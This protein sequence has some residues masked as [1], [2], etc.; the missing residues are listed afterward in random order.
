MKCV[1]PPTD[2]K[3]QTLFCLLVAQ[4]NDVVPLMGLVPPG[5]NCGLRS[6]VG[7]SCAVKPRELLACRSEHLQACHNQTARN[8]CRLL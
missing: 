2:G 6:L 3:D 1:Q 8:D 7:C 5:Q 4:A